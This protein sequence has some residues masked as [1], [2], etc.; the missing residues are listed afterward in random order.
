MKHLKDR[1]YWTLL[2]FAV[3]IGFVFIFIFPKNGFIYANITIIVFWIVYYT[4]TY[5]D[6]KQSGKKEG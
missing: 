3:I 5:I 1:I 2:P 6:K 4:W